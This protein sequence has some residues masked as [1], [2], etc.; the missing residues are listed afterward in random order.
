[1]QEETPHDFPLHLGPF[2]PTQNTHTLPEGLPLV[3]VR[4]LYLLGAASSCTSIYSCGTPIRNM[5]IRFY[6]SVKKNPKI[7]NNFLPSFYLSQRLSP[8]HPTSSTLTSI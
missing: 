8:M 7:L 1:V 3:R 4:T 6:S 5:K 2:G